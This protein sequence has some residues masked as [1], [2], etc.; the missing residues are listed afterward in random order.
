[1]STIILRNY[2]KSL[3]DEVFTAWDDGHTNVLVQSHTGSGK[4]VILTEIV[5]RANVPTIIV[6]HRLELV[7]QLSLALA[8]AEIQH[9]ILSPLDSIS[10]II[11]TQLQLEHKHYY[12]PRAC[13]TIASVDT[14][15]R[16]QPTWCDDIQLVVIDEAAHVLQKNKWGK[17]VNM[18]PQ[19]RGLLVTAT[20]LRADGKGLGRNADGIA[21]VLLEGPSMRELIAGGHLSEY[22]IYAPPNSLDLTPVSL[23]ASGDFSPDPLRKA[24]TKASITGDVIEHFKRLGGHLGITFAVS[25]EA[26]QELTAAYNEAGIPAICLHASTGVLERTSIMRQFRAGTIRQL[27]NVDILAEGV[28]VPA[29]S[30][31]SLCRPTASYGLYMQQIGR[32]LRPAEGK[33]HAIILDHVGNV[34]RHG[35]PDV[36][37]TWTL[38]A[39][40]RRSRTTS[41]AIPLR[42]CLNTTCVAV[43]ERHRDRCPYCNHPIPLPKTRA[44]PDH[45]EGNLQELLPDSLKRITDEIARIER[46]PRIPRNVSGIVASSIIKRH[47]MRQD[48]QNRLKE[49]IALWA[50]IYHAHGESDSEIQRRFWFNFGID[51]LSAQTLSTPDALKLIQRLV[52]NSST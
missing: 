37:R 36:P 47:H 29:V 27:V 20:P 50:G 14:L 1:M 40:D 44:L 10:A 23:S 8:R 45:V 26:A 15:I 46:A 49:V 34:M 33:T 51:I 32:A 16:R 12:N 18:F 21:D 31:V 5:K 17:A 28:D 2:Q 42:T 25:V 48:T 24:V 35:L 30:C 52:D 43:F 3:I 13:V 7:S 4:T 11:S 9:N 38:A 41:S 6:A 19:A 22:R 39:Q